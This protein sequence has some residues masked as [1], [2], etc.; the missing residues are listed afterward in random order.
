MWSQE[1]FAV[2]PDVDGMLDVARK[3]FLQSMED[4]YQTADAMSEENGYQVKV[5]AERV[6]TRLVLRV[7]RRDFPSAARFRRHRLAAKVNGGKTVS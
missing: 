2:R 5:G 4:I 1:C 3:T 6:A 7:L